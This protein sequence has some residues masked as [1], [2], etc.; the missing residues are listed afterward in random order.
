MTLKEPAIKW[1]LVDRFLIASTQG[2][3]T[4]VIIINKIDLL[5]SKEE[6][7]E[8]KDMVATYRALGV[9]VLTLS[10]KALQGTDALKDLLKD[11]V[12]SFV[13]P[14]GTGKST[15]LSSILG[16]KLRVGE[17][18]SHTQK[19]A[20][21]TTRGEIFFLPDG[22]S[23][24]DTPGIK[25][26]ALWDSPEKDLQKYFTEIL[27]ASQDCKFPNCYHIQEPLC[28]VK[29]KVE[30]GEIH[31]KR[32]NSYKYIFENLGKKDLSR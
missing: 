16:R 5:T 15:I 9:I 22:G 17:L 32:Y 28:A 12:S 25:S 13:G 14:S 23:C 27:E 18:A 2:N 29:N 26:F 10:A 3:T 19:G 30:S 21:T 31:K 24:I 6:Q 11:K 8:L 7:E 4:P 20:H 1:S